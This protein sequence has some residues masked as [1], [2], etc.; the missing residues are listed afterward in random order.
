MFFRSLN[1][2]VRAE[3]PGEPQ[4]LLVLEEASPGGEE[5]L[6]LALTALICIPP[7]CMLIYAANMY[8]AYNKKEENLV[9]LYK[10]AAHTGSRERAISPM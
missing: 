8:P 7:T 5:H 3:H 9:E 6:G 10:E 1:C 4:V 2:F